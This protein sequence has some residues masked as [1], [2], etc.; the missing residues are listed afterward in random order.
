M[1]DSEILILSQ[2]RVRF[3][4]HNWAFACTEDEMSIRMPGQ[5]P[6]YNDGK[7][8]CNDGSLYLLDLIAVMIIYAD[9]VA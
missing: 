9:L 5:R 7:R 4:F 6:Y 1:Q 3:S 2:L 8:D